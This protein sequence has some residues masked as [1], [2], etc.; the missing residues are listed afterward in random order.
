[1]LQLPLPEL[2]LLFPLIAHKE[3]ACL[4]GFIALLDTSYLCS[5][6]VTVGV[7][8]SPL[9]FAC[10]VKKT[11]WFYSKITLG[12]WQLPH[13]T[14]YWLPTEKQQY[15]LSEGPL[16]QRDWVEWHRAAQERVPAWKSRLWPQHL[17]TET[18]ATLTFASE[19]APS[20]TYW[21]ACWTPVVHCCL[22]AVGRYRQVFA[23]K[24]D[25]RFS[26]SLFISFQVPIRHWCIGRWQESAGGGWEALWDARMLDATHRD[27]SSWGWK[28]TVTNLEV[29][30]NAIK[31]W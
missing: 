2:L 16:R 29:Y 14:N 4:R 11:Y 31:W 15:S 12:S 6:I 21:H 26:F 1:M 18:S 9:E 5:W 22:T 24:V 28:G 25:T 27:L 10:R 3:G 7:R 19:E 30:F 20:K 8:W 23:D 17:Q 13:S